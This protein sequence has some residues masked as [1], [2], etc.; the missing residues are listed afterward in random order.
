M[1]LGYSRSEMSDIEHP[2]GFEVRLTLKYLNLEEPLTMSSVLRLRHHKAHVE[3]ALLRLQLRP[4]ENDTLPHN[5]GEYRDLHQSCVF[6][7]VRSN[8]IRIVSER[9]L[10]NEE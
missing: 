9:S 5:T 4:Q 6:V 2:D 7:Q 3:A 1:N 8:M 10:L